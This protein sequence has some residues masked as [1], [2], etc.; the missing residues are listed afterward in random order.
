MEYMTRML[1]IIGL[2]ATLL[3]GYPFLEPLRYGQKYRSGIVET[4]MTKVIISTGIGT[5]T[6]LVRFFARPE[7]ILLT[8]KRGV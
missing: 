8:L 2:S 1:F 3:L 4:V 5:I 7:I 6:P